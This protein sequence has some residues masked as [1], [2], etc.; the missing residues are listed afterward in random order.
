MKPLFFYVQNLS[1]KSL[2][3]LPLCFVFFLGYSQTPQEPYEVDMLLEELYIS[4]PGT[5]SSHQKAA[6]PSGARL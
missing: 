4:A 5:M 3:V 1:P 2:H 6:I